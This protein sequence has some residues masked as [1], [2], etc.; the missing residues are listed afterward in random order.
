MSEVLGN[1]K[2]P[3]HI[4][5]MILLYNIRQTLSF[6]DNREISNFQKSPSKSGKTPCN[7][8]FLFIDTSLNLADG[9]IEKCR[10]NGN[11]WDG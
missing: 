8:V 4:A 3:F 7:F 11:G 6:I 2:D 1:I 9:R 5:L 10:R